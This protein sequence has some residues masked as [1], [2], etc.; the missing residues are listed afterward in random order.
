MTRS[1][2][3]CGVDHWLHLAAGFQGIVGMMANLNAQAVP[4]SDEA[5]AKLDE[6]LAR[7]REQI[8]QQRQL[9]KGP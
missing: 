3:P 9:R 7:L 2:C 1:S 8:D 5:M 4:A 6:Q